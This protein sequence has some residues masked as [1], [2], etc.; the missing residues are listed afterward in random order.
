[1][2][3]AGH[4]LGYLTFLAFAVALLVAP[5]VFGQPFLLW[6]VIPLLIA[7]VGAGFL[8]RKRILD[9][10]FGTPTLVATES[11]VP[12]Q[13]VDLQLSLTPRRPIRPSV[14]E[15]ELMGEEQAIQ[16][17]ATSD[18][19]YTH[20]FER[21]ND[22]SR[23]PE[24]WRAGQ[25]ITLRARLALPG[26]APPSFAAAN[27][28]LRWWAIVRVQAPWTPTLA[29]QQ[30]IRVSLPE[31]PPLA[32]AAGR[33]TLTATQPG[34]S[35]ELTVDAPNEAGVPVLRPGG[36]LTGDLSVRCTAATEARQTS[37]RLLR[38][39]HG[40]GTAEERIVEET[41]LQ[42]GALSTGQTLTARLDWPVPLTNELSYAGRHLKCDWVLDVQVDRPHGPDWHLRVPLLLRAV[43]DTARH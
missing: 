2:R 17:G 42:P 29:L 33:T 10:T 6:L 14:V 36:Q 40:S 43:G 30:P 27:H 3:I 25:S 24:P 18:S 26:T 35:G 4:G 12:G 22:A 21:V 38:L 13:S 15:W 31:Q 20:T 16:R 8:L 23:H 19:T 34:L 41:V 32:P 9:L 39:L 5:F 7:I 28:S 37:L 1:M 11:A